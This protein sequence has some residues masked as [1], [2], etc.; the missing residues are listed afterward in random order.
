MEEHSPS[1]NLKRYLHT[2]FPIKVQKGLKAVFDFHLEVQITP[3]YFKRH[4]EAQVFPGKTAAQCWPCSLKYKCDITE[5]HTRTGRD[6]YQLKA[7]ALELDSL[8]R[9]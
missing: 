5:V 7:K 4:R 1:Y 2:V 6:T 3:G 9:G 8:G